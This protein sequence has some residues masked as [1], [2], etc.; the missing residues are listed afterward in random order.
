VN[1]RFKLLILKDLREIFGKTRKFYKV[2][3]PSTLRGLPFYG[4]KEIEDWRSKAK[5]LLR[6]ICYAKNRKKSY[7]CRIK[8]YEFLQPKSFIT[9]HS[10]FLTPKRR[11]TN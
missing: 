5:R 11:Y 2:L 10:S 4:E 8:N 9:H 6:Q 3:K 1:L 7:E